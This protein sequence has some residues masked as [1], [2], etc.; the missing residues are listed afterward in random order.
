MKENR[1]L[2]KITT[3]VNIK[4]RVYSF[5]LSLFS[6]IWFLKLPESRHIDQ[7]NRTESPEINSYICDQLLFDKGAKTMQWGENCLFTNCGGT[8]GYPK[9]EVSSYYTLKWT[10]NGNK[11]KSKK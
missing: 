9:S 7:W 4:E 6:Y 8:T 3:W 2:L 10:Q 11:P 1:A 5:P